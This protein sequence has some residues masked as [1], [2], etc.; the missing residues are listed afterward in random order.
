VHVDPLRQ[1]A[2]AIGAEIDAAMSRSPTGEIVRLK[3]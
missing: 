2:D 3:T 1:A